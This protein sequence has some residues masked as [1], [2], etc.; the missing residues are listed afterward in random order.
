M[1]NLLA[2][3][4]VLVFSLAPNLQAYTIGGAHATLLECKW[5]KWG[6]EYGYIGTYGVGKK[7]IQKFFGDEYCEY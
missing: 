5:G 2:V 7:K 6:Y 1:K 3:I 4:M